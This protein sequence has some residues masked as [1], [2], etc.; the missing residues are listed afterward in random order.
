MVAWEKNSHKKNQLNKATQN[1]A[2]GFFLIV[3]KDVDFINFFLS[4]IFMIQMN[5]LVMSLANRPTQ[6]TF[7]DLDL[8]LK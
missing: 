8:C 4:S 7:F 6:N 3:L 2:A 1:L 5:K